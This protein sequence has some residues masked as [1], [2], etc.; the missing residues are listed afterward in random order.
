MNGPRGAVR[1]PLA[2][3]RSTFGT[4]GDL[5][6]LGLWTLYL[7][8]VRRF[9]KVTMQTLVAP[10]VTTLMFL[11][12]FVLALGGAGRTVAGVPFLQFLAPGLLVMAVVQNAFA[13]TSSSVMIAKMQGNIIDYLMPPLGPGELTFGIVMG[14]VTRGML[15]AGTVWLA[16]LPVAPFLPPHP[17][18]LLASLFLAST[19][20]SLLGLIAAIWADKF[21]H[22]AGV[23]N[24]V[25][26]PLSFLSGTF[27][28]LEALPESLHLVALANPFFHAI[29]TARWAAT[30]HADGPIPAG[31]TMLVL[32]NVALWLTAWQMLK[33]GY[34]L[35][36]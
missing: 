8:E 7:K 3:D 13:N 15:V 17:L 21:D 14:G 19:M 5:N 32:V 29:D 31:Y 34:K 20:L 18:A 6:L 9:L 35:K 25:I 27:Y 28:S 26:T 33:R 2:G 23:T 11:A 24:F 30:G 16:L 12:V 1:P 22:M 10:M 36:A 4:W